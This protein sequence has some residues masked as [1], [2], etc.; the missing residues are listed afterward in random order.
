[1][2]EFSKRQDRKGYTKRLYEQH[3]ERLKNMKPT[4]DNREPKH[5]P[6]S[7]KWENEYNRKIDKINDFNTKLVYRLINKTSRID[8]QLDRRMKEVLDFK[9]QM[10]INKRRMEMEKIVSENI[11]L[12]NRLKNIEPTLKN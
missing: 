9:R 8:N 7:K 4:V 6:Y 1:M 3:L 12:L 11:I 2:L 10:M 5:L